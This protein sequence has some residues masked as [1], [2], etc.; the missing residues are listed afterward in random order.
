[1]KKA[2]VIGVVALAMISVALF[3]GRTAVKTRGELNPVFT[4]H[5]PP[6]CAKEAM[7]MTQ[8][9]QKVQMQAEYFRMFQD[10]MNACFAKAHRGSIEQGN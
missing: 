5:V 2:I 4:A 8:G 9:R 7:E 3:A 10:R 6:E 1:M